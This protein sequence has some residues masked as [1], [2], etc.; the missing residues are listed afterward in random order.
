MAFFDSVEGGVSIIALFIGFMVCYFGRAMINWVLFYISFIVILT[1]S[2]I[3]FYY[4]F[5]S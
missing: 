3:I 2:W 1:L 4:A 5:Y